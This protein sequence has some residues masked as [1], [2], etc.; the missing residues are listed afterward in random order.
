MPVSSFSPYCSFR[1]IKETKTFS[2]FIIISVAFIKSDE[3][4]FITCSGNPTL[5]N[6]VM[7]VLKMATKHAK[8]VTVFI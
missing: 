2:N 7:V 1:E 6:E 5:S 4:F 8:V 3:E